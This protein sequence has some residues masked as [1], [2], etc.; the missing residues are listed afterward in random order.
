MAYVLAPRTTY[1]LTFFNPANPSIAQPN[2]TLNF[3][4]QQHFSRQALTTVMGNVER[5]LAREAAR[6]MPVNFIISPA[7]PYGD[8]V[9][10]FLMSA[11]GARI[12]SWEVGDPVSHET[13]A[14]Y[15]VSVQ[16]AAQAMEN[17]RNETVAFRRK[18][19]DDA[20]LR[21]GT[22]RL[23]TFAG[24]EQL[25]AVD[26]REVPAVLDF[27]FQNS[28]PYSGEWR[29]DFSLRWTGYMWAEQTSEYR[30]DATFDDGCRVFL[31]DHLLFADWA[32]GSAR[33]ATATMNLEAGWHPI[34][35]D[36][37][38]VV[39]ESRFLFEVRPEGEGVAPL[40]A[41]AFASDC[42]T[43]TRSET[44]QRASEAH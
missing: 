3:E 17:W 26:E 18:P 37:F 44:Q 24:T 21:R 11:P 34:R 14:Y 39:N 12:G 1:R 31:D 22:L 43:G 4:A 23:T 25:L 8:T 7:S 15:L 32:P 20:Q 42:G 41:G 30:F 28:V 27:D 16:N 5:V 19:A 10:Q 6:R 33:K 29:S 9:R 2:A 13:T 35:I 36:Y 40:A 38:R